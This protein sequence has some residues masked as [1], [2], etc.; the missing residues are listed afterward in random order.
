M[1]DVHSDD[2]LY[3]YH[4]DD[5][6]QR[7]PAYLQSDLDQ[8]L[9]RGQSLTT[10]EVLSLG[11]SFFAYM[12]TPPEEWASEDDLRFHGDEPGF[13]ACPRGRCYLQWKWVHDDD[14]VYG[15]L[16]DSTPKASADLIDSVR[17]NMTKQFRAVKEEFTEAVRQL[18]S[19][20]SEAGGMWKKE[21]N[22]AWADGFKG[23]QTGAQTNESA[24]PI[25]RGGCVEFE[26]R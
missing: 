7:T 18:E 21:W 10:K 3:H 25:V 22:K 11:P 13:R 17:N 15:W 20:M 5:K 9:A 14:G 8:K 26:H 16:W 4:C 2:Y 6:T 19:E 23:S 24:K 1:D 12:K